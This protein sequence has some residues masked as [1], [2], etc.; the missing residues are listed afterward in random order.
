MGR[1]RVRGLAQAIAFALMACGGASGGGAV[2]D[3]SATDGE[4][5]DAAVEHPADSTTEAG[6]GQEASD[7]SGQHG[8]GDDSS[9][10]SSADADTGIPL[11]M[12][13]SDAPEDN[14][15]QVTATPLPSIDD[16]DSSGSTVSAISSG[17]GD[18]DWTHY[19]GTDPALALCTVDP[20]AQIDAPGLRVCIFI[21]CPTGTTT[22]TS[23][24]NGSPDTSPAGSPGCCTTSTTAMTVKLSCGG[25]SDS[26][27]VYMR[28][29]Q[30]SSDQCVPYDLAYHF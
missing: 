4:T 7:D 24:T 17:M 5:A 26:A 10:D 20:T 6:G 3:A 2:A 25:T 13:G 27:D 12:C 28:V 15:T 9:A 19:F 16:C 11:L 23:C 14:G 18:T 30:P 22:I 1:I 8:S 21:I 29:D